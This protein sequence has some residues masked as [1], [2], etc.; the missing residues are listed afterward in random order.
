MTKRGQHPLGVLGRDRRLAIHFAGQVI[1]KAANKPTAQIDA[2]YQ[3]A[4]SR[5]PT[6]EELQLGLDSLAI[7]NKHWKESG[8]DVD[9]LSRK[10]LASFCHGMMNSA[11]F[12]YLD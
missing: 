7:L 6:D 11:A 5:R 12:L 3:V 2:V 4:L 9:D 10:A 8:V 1:A